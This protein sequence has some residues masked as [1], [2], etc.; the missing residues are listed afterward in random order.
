MPVLAADTRVFGIFGSDGRT[1]YALRDR[2]MERFMERTGLTLVEGRLPR[3]G[4][5]E[6]ALHA[7]IL[8]GKDGVAVGGEIGREVSW[9]WPRGF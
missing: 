5:A 4:K 1:I 8:K 2:D 9:P 6:V 3:P 7:D